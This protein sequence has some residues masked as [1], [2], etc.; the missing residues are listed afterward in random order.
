[1]PQ[2]RRSDPHPD[3]GPR[4]V[5]ARGERIVGFAADPGDPDRTIRRASRAWCV[6]QLYARG[7]LP[8]T[9]LQAAERWRDSRATAAIGASCTASFLRSGIHGAAEGLTPA[10]IV[11]RAASDYRRARGALA[12][13]LAVVLDLAA[14]EELSLSDLAARVRLT[15]DRASE[16]VLMAT[17][18][19]ARH[20]GLE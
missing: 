11:M 6:M 3:L 15:E 1:M 7:A 8:L 4:I 13:A 19:L 10:E 14:A 17:G 12:P 18:A 16:A 5:R 9:H 20:Y 2:A